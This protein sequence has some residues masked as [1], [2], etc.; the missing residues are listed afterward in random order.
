MINKNKMKSSKSNDNDY[1]E[2]NSDSNKK[3]NYIT[4]RPIKAYY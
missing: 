1:K 4:K 2:N 3:D